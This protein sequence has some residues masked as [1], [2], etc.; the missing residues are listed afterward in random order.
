[1]A[2]M[3]ETPESAPVVFKAPPPPAKIYIVMG[4]LSLRKWFPGKNAGPGDWLKMPDGE[5]EALVIMSPEKIVRFA[6]V[7]PAVQKLKYE[8]WQSLK[9]AIGKARLQ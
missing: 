3:S 7:T 6:T 8:M 4:A 5:T 9:T 2:A 1:M